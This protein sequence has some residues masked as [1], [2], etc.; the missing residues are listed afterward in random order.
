M[1]LNTVV[2]WAHVFGAIGWLGA[3]LVF[4]IVLGPALPRLSAQARLEF[5]ATVLPRYIRYIRMFAVVTVVF[6][7]ATV[8]VIADGDYSVLSPSTPF[9][10]YVSAGALLALAVVGLAFGVILPTASRIAGM[11]GAL[12]KAPG[13][14]PP[15]LL[16]ASERLRKGSMAGLVLLMVVTVLMVA[17]AT[18]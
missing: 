2:L 5:L 3:A 6:G 15:E 9:G 10:L 14:P 12:L 13:P 16:A 4:A 18:L 7:V 1:I 11:S 8:L 17:S